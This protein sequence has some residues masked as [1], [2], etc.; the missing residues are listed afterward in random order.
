MTGL[1]SRLPP[2]FKKRPL[3]LLLEQHR[4]T[5]G[6]TRKGCLGAHG[7]QGSEASPN[8]RDT[9]AGRQD[10]VS[11]TW[12]PAG[13]PPVRLCPRSP[14]VGALLAGCGGRSCPLGGGIKS[15]S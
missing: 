12:R 14:L 8:L 2:L 3:L 13:T 10:S 6:R 7:V 5:G 9:S 4:V 11:P 1:P 15:A